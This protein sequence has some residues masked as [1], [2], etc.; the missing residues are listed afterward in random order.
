[1]IS[2]NIAIKFS[3]FCLRILKDK[4]RAQEVLK[5][6]I[7]KDPNNPRLYLQLIDLTLQF[8]DATESDILGLIDEFLEKETADADQK[9]L[10]A[11][12]K[13]E[14]LEDFGCDIASVQ[15]AYE[16]Y[17]KYIKLSKDGAKKKEN[18]R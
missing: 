7:T 13:L 3:R 8:D 12:R 11:Q 1:M 5:L 2:S 4:N 6:A 14:F 10:F 16:Q 15:N 17:Q 18:K 9:V